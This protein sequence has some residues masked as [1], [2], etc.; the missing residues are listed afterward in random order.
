[1]GSISIPIYAHTNLISH[2][3][4]NTGAI[5]YETFTGR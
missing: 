3:H 5:L 4:P 2:R 1:M